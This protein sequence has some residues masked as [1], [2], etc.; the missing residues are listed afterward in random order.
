MALLLKLVRSFWSIRR[1]L[2]LRFLVVHI[3]GKSFLNV[4]LEYDCLG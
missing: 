3:S 1:F 4:G 2:F